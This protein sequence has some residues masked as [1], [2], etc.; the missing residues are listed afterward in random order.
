VKLR[1]RATAY[2]RLASVACMNYFYVW[3]ITQ[4]RS[5]FRAAMLL[6]LTLIPAWGIYTR[7]WALLSL[8]PLVGLVVAVVSE[9]RLY[10]L[11]LVGFVGINDVNFTASWTIVLITYGFCAATFYLVIRPLLGPKGQALAQSPA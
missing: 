7:N 4:D 11:D 9:V 2:W 10:I 3:A 6:S 5:C 8:Y 1:R